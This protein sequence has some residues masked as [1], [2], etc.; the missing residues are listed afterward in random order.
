MEDR[1]VGFIWSLGWVGWG[2]G[3]GLDFIWGLMMEME[4]WVVVG[5]LMFGIDEVSVDIIF[6]ILDCW[7]DFIGNKRNFNSLWEIVV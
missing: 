3:G 5:I 2:K 6:M 7:C 4:E 1:T